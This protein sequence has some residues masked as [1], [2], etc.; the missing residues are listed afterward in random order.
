MA[1]NDDARGRRPR[2]RIP[3]ALAV[4]IVGT[5]ATVTISAGGCDNGSPEPVDASSSGMARIDAAVDAE[6]DS[7]LPADAQVDAMPDTPVT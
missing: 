2:L 1:S 5:S 4:A 7:E 6:V 3:A